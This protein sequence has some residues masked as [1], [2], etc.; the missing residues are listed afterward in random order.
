[1]IVPLMLE[2]AMTKTLVKT[3][4]MTL[5]AM[6]KMRTLFLLQW[7]FIAKFLFTLNL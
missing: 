6:M 3:T 5:L 4:I 7:A 2:M 1:M